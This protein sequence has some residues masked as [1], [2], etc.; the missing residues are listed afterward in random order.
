MLIWEPEV[1]SEYL[2]SN[3]GH[4]LWL[5]DIF[6]SEKTFSTID[7]TLWGGGGGLSELLKVEFWSDYNG[8]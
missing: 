7:M 8:V 2:R 6:S 5:Q 1:F 3:T 4:L